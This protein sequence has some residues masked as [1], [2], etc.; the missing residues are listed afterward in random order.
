MEPP[1]I[2]RAL[3]RHFGI[4]A[5]TLDTAG[6]L[7]GRRG[8]P[9]VSIAAVPA[10][11]L[12]PTGAGDACAAGFLTE[13]VRCHDAVAAAGFGVRAGARAVGTIGGRPEG[14]QILSEPA[15]PG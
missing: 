14:Q 1:D 13:W 6:V 7:V 5:I 12:D 10:R 15:T 11:V 2:A 8:H 9:L 3:L 4:V